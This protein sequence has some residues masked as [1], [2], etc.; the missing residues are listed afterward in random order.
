M[1][2]AVAPTGNLRLGHSPL[3]MRAYNLNLHNLHQHLTSRP[4]LS[5][6]GAEEERL[7]VMGG[8]GRC[9]YIDTHI[10]NHMGSSPLTARLQG[11]TGRTTNRHRSGS[12]RA[13]THPHL[14]H[15]SVVAERGIHSL[16]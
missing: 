8:G 1:H 5:S 9:M 4:A 12:F 11:A 7:L 14:Y 13:Y 15:I 16:S 2:M 6:L 3:A 10:R